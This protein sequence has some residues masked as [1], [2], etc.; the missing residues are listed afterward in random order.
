MPA[1]E[2]LEEIQ[3]TGDIFFPKRWL[4]A[5]LGGHQSSEAVEIVESFL[6]DNPDY[7]EKLKAKILQSLDMTKRA[8]S[9]RKDV[10][11]AM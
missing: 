1:L 3:L 2:L 6:K 11:D 10:I 8:A 4:D 9:I 5:V 7:P